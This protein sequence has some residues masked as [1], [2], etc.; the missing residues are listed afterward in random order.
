M[1]LTD[2]VMTVLNNL[3]INDDR[4]RPALEEHWKDEECI[5]WSTDDVIERIKER[6]SVELS[7]HNARHILSMA[8]D[9]H[10]AEFGVCWET[11]DT[12]YQNEEE[13]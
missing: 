8:I 13:D 10:D 3:G 11:F 7:E 1:K 5:V 9:N 4:I 12:I 6:F 2:D